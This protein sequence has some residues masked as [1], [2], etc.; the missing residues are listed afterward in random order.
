MEQVFVT[1]KL[2]RKKG[3]FCDATRQQR[4]RGSLFIALKISDCVDWHRHCLTL[5][6]LVSEHFMVI[7]VSQDLT[8]SAN[9]LFIY[10]TGLIFKYIVSQCQSRMDNTELL[11]SATEFSFSVPVMALHRG[12]SYS[13]MHWPTSTAC[14]L[15]VSQCSCWWNPCVTL[16]ALWATTLLPHQQKPDPSLGQCAGATLT[17]WIKRLWGKRALHLGWRFGTTGCFSVDVPV[18]PYL[19]CFPE[20]SALFCPSRTHRTDVPLVTWCQ[21]QYKVF[22]FLSLGSKKDNLCMHLWPCRTLL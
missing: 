3:R 20:S 22:H 16:S 8:I 11:T 15:H 17:R 21:V 9:S 12:R 10:I 6:Q 14:Y 5:T 19:L 4:E 13:F 2:L 7:F 18:F 1:I